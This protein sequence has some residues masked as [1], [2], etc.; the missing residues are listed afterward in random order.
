MPVERKFSSAAGK[1]FPEK[2]NIWWRKSEF[3]TFYANALNLMTFR[4]FMPRLKLYDF[5]FFYATWDPY[6]YIIC[7][8]SVANPSRQSIY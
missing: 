1:F 6:K 4:N 7:S 5:L 8:L 2:N 3:I